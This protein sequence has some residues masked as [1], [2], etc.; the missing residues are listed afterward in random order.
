GE[1]RRR[2][3]GERSPASPAGARRSRASGPD[4]RPRGPWAWTRAPPAVLERLTWGRAGRASRAPRASPAADRLANLLDAPA[5]DHALWTRVG[6]ADL[7]AGSGVC[8]TLLDQEPGLA[9]LIPSRPP[10]DPDESPAAV[11]LRAV[12]REFQLAGSERSDGMSDG[13]PGTPVPQENGAASVLA[14]RDYALEAPVLER[15]ILGLHGQP[16]VGRIEARPLGDCPAREDAVDLQTEVVVEAGG[17]M[18]LDDERRATRFRRDDPARLG[19]PSEVPLGVIEGERR[20]STAGTP[21]S[22]SRF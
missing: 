11:Q 22:C 21:P 14:C 10:P 18:L 13:S 12:E 3:G 2:G 5:A 6:N 9:T 1:A 15:V 8:V 20:L 7:V 19:R 4:G 17:V 16:L